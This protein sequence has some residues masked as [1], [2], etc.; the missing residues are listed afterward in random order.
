MIKGNVARGSGRQGIFYTSLSE[1]KGWGVQET[2]VMARFAKTLDM[3][4][5]YSSLTK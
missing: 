1:K 5:R 3:A 4:L 2:L